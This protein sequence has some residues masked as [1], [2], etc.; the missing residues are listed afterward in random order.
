MLESLKPYSGIL[1]V[2][3]YIAIALFILF[4]IFYIQDL[5]HEKEIALI[6]KQMERVEETAKFKQQI[7]DLDGINNYLQ[8]DN[9]T[10]LDQLKKDNIKTNRIESIISQ[11]LKY[12]DTVSRKTD[13]TPLLSYIKQN[14]V[15]SMPFVD[16]TKCL[17]IKGFIE[18]KN[19]SLKLN[20]T[21]RDISNKNDI[22]AYWERKEWRF[23]FFKTRFLGKKE[24]TAKNY[25]ECG[26]AKVVRIERKK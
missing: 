4:G 14:K 24:F 3:G 21:S 13:F 12:R 1:K 20:I 26:E 22:V 10:L 17:K 9:K 18:Y 15:Y 7:E 8:R 25:N 6:N 16:S 5:K 19:D 23:L 11:V 2:I